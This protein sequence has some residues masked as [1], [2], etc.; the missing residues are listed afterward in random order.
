M[1]HVRKY[2]PILLLVCTGGLLILI[3]IDSDEVHTEF[4]F[5]NRQRQYVVRAPR[6]I[7]QGQNLPVIVFLHGSAPSSMPARALLDGPDGLN[8]I[9]A[10]VVESESVLAVAPLAQHSCWFAKNLICFDGDITIDSQVPPPRTDSPFLDAILDDIGNQYPID[11]NRVHLIGHSAGGYVAIL[12]ALGNS[13]AYAGAV[14]ISGSTCYDECDATTVALA[15]SAD[16]LPILLV[17]NP[18]D[19]VV[20]PG[21][22]ERLYSLLSAEGYTTEL[23]VDYDGGFDGH[24]L[25]SSLSPLIWLW[26]QRPHLSN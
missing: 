20:N 15:K 2:L 3:L 22:S 16:K 18:A 11:R 23:I 13:S 10:E 5:D 21:T 12:L 19:H 24:R 25:D 9:W 17:H 14:S 1:L 6:Q 4:V 26:L 8:A 7:V